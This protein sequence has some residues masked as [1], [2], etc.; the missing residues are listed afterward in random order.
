VIRGPP[1]VR[2][3]YFDGWRNNWNYKKTKLLN[4][5]VEWFS[6]LLRVCAVP[7]S[8]FGPET[9]YPD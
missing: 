6:R 3:H 2:E 4:V 5:L 9:G 8:N 7:G 1:V